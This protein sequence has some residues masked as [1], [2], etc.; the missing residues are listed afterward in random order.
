MK[1]WQSLVRQ[2]QSR[3]TLSDSGALLTLQDNG[4]WHLWPVVEM[5]IYEKMDVTQNIRIPSGGLLGGS[6]NP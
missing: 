1:L 6:Y 3:I 4:E 2:K 5:Q